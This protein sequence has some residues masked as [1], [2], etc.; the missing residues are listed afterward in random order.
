[1]VLLSH[2]PSFLKLLWDRVQPADRK[3]L[4][5]ARIGEEN[6]T[7]VE[8]DIEKAVQAR[9][10]ADIEALHRFFSDGEGEPREVIQ[11]LRPVL[12][13]YCRTLYPT[14]FADADTLGV[15]VGK[16]RAAGAGH[17]L[18][19]IADD[20]DEVNM[21]CRRYHHAEN[22]NAATEPIDDAELQGYV[23][24]TLKLVGCLL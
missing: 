5:F 14:Q 15:I 2:E 10:K 1:V 4:Q 23:K 24:R 18:R 19:P 16:I 9:Y 13:G 21:Y 11:K 3:T 8:W 20:L 7:I 6:T 22:P 12:E 17:P